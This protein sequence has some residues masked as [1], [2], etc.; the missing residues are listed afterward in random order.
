MDELWAF[1]RYVFWRWFRR[2][3]VG[4]TWANRSGGILVFTISAVEQN[5]V[6]GLLHVPGTR[7]GTPRIKTSRDLIAFWQR[8]TE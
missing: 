4:E 2:P 7:H 8:L 3:Q 5:V 6:F 1:L